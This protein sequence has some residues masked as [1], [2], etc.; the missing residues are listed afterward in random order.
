MAYSGVLEDIRKCINLNIPEKVPVFA[1]SEGF[2]VRMYDLTYA[3][4]TYNAKKMASCRIDA[5]KRFDYDWSCGWPDDYVEIEPLGVKL[6]GGENIPLTACEPLEASWKTL[7]SLKIPDFQKDGRMPAYLDVLNK[8]KKE[9]SD[10]IC[11][12]GRVSAPFSSAGLLYGIREALELMID[13][14]ELLRKTMDFC[15]ELQIGWGKAQIAAGADA[16]W[17]GDCLASSGFIS[18]RHYTEFAL[19]EA[20]KISHALKESGA[21]VFYHAGEKSLSHLE[22]MAQVQASAL[23]IGEGIDISLAKGTVGKKICLVGNIDS[24][25]V[26]QRGNP[27]EVAQ[28]TIRIMEA[29][30]RGGGYIFNSGESIPPQT[31]EGN[32]RAMIQ[33][34]RKHGLYY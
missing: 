30:K 8:I 16:I 2:D 21:I 17:L 25:R 31:P 6:K 15:I 13:N 24:I 18:P 14:P 10:T 5:V 29:G 11:L 20:R 22:L 9:L 34:A 19:E 32:V 4:Y 1:I 27:E 3:E 23:S 28:E 33:T 7:S 12:T 26:L